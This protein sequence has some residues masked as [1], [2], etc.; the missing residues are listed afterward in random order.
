MQLVITVSEPLILQN[1]Y[2]IAKH[3]V[4]GASC[5]A[6]ICYIEMEEL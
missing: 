3:P 5:P 2:F 1:L 6:T 4:G